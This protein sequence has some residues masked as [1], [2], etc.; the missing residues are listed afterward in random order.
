ME[1]RAKYLGLDAPA[2]KRVEVITEDVIDREIARLQAEL[3]ING[4][5]QP[6]SPL[7]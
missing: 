2:Q 5:Q 7:R 1:R 4:S 6:G 3:G